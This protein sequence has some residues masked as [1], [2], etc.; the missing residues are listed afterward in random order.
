[1]VNFERDKEKVRKRLQL[2]SKFQMKELKQG[3]FNY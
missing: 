1:M 2:A 3:L